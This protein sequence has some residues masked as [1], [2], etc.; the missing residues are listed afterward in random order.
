MATT[1]DRHALL[2]RAEERLRVSER[3]I[4]RWRQR[5]VL[6]AVQPLA[7]GAVRY[8]VEDVEALAEPEN[9]PP[10]PPLRLDELEWS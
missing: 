6:R 1:V 7:G 3:T 5:R 4:D 9:R 8:R 10:S 2:T